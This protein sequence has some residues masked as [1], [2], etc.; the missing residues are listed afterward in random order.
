MLNPPNAIK[1]LDITTDCKG[2]KPSIDKSLQPR[3]TSTIPPEIALP[4]FLSPR[5]D[6]KKLK[7]E[8]KGVRILKSNKISIIM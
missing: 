7:N 3:V 2:L 8:V 4:A 6:S 1:P 5:G